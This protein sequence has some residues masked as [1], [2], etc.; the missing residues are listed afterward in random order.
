MTARTILLAVAGV[1]ITVTAAGEDWPQWRGPNRDAKAIGFNAPATLPR[2][3]KQ[4]WRVEV[5]DGVANPS[6]VG[7]RLYVI[8]LQGSTEITRC[9]SAKDG[10]DIWKD[11]YATKGAEG[12]A[13]SFA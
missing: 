12:A 13:Q 6:L 2:S 5:G 4:Q 10:K 7:D 11:E 1:A 3:L 8:A 9:L